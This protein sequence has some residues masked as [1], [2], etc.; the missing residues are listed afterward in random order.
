MPQSTL[1]AHILASFLTLQPPGLS[2]HSVV[3][4]SEDS[5]PACDASHS[6]LCAP[7]RYS[8]AHQSFVRPESRSEGLERYRQLAEVMAATVIAMTWR[9]HPTCRPLRAVRWAPEATTDECTALQQA[10]PW[11]GSQR[12]LARYL[13]AVAYHESGFRRDVQSGVGK[14]SKGDRGKSHCLAQ[15]L[16][17]KS[18]RRKK[19]ARGYT[20]K[21]LTGIDKESTMRCLVT[22]VDY[23]SH[24]RNVSTSPY[25]P[26]QRG[27]TAVFMGYGG[28]TNARD[29]RIRARVSTYR[30][31]QALIPLNPPSV[32]SPAA[33]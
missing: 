13:V 29:P 1:A 9:P 30:K 18:G 11:R 2:P 12:E 15:I 5:A 31:L 25:G 22:M 3:E 21:Q 19:T 4:V 27:P 20:G 16:L 6:P 32:A 33:R 10:R 23:L 17:D 28:V 8:P 26:T 24:S 14:W 7:P